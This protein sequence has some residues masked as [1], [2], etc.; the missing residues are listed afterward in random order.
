MSRKAEKMSF[1]LCGETCPALDGL[2]YAAYDEISKKL[3][4]DER[5]REV[6]FNILLDDYCEKFK[7][8]GTHLLRSALN[9]ACET[10]IN[11]EDKID[12]LEYGIGH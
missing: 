4:L 5:S 1:G 8:V 6:V 10:I 3:D 2:V 12:D 11:L 9:E 7:D